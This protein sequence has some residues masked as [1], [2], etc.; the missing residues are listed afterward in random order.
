VFLHYVSKI[1]HIILFWVAFIFTRPFGATFGDFLTKP[2]EKGGLQLG[3]LN[4][5]I[6][7]FG[8]MTILLFVAHRQQ[9]NNKIRNN[10]IIN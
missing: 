10:R 6:I 9:R 2:I 3:T 1:N 8:V 4:S 7:S 5:S